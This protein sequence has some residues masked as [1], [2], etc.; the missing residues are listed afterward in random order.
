MSQIV[1]LNRI[2]KA[3]SRVDAR[4]TADENAVKFGQ[5]KA[6]KTLQAAKADKSR[7]ELDAAKRE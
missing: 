7:R 6:Q 1:N 2:R 5:T 4:R 3:Q